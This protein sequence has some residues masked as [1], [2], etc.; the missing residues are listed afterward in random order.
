VPSCSLSRWPS[1]LF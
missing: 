1:V